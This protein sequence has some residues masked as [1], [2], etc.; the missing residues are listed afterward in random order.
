MPFQTSLMFESAFPSEA[1]F[2]GSTL[3]FT[4]GANV[5]KLFT[6]VIYCHSMAIPSF[7]AIKL[8]YLGNY[9]GMAVNYHG[10]KLFY[11]IGQK[12]VL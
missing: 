7:C 11:N 4:P 12:S 1:P 10:I 5:I 9:H 8:Y 3:G 2:R 6:M